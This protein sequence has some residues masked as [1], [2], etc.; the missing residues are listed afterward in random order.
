MRDPCVYCG[1]RA[2]GLDHI[3]PRS[4]RGSDEWQN[5]APACASCDTTK[6]STSLLYFLTA[7][8]LIEVVVAGRGRYKTPEE[9]RS[10]AFRILKIACFP[11]DVYKK[12]WSVPAWL[13]DPVKA[14]ART[15]RLTK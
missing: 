15:F 4:R 1:A 7:R 2:D 5:R 11:R 8:R 6:H 3:V 12:G 9:R 13:V 10:A 14:Y